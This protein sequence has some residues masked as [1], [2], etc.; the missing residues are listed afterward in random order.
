MKPTLVVLA[1]GMG[2]RY[3]GL[4]QIDEFGPSGEAIIEYSIFDAIRAGF[5]K[6]V[7]IIRKTIEKDF[8]AFIGNKFEGKIDI[9][10]AYQELDHL[11]EGFTAPEGREKPWG[12]AHAM[13]V[14]KDVVNEPFAIINADDFYGADAY[15][16]MGNFL[17]QLSNDSNSYALLGYYVKNTL[18]ENGSVSRGVCQ[19]NENNFLESITERTKIYPQDNNIVF[20]E[21][22]K[23]TTLSPETPVSMNFMG[24]TPAVFPL[25]EE[26]F[27]AFLEKDINTPKSEFF[28]PLALSLFVEEKLATVTVLETAAKWFGVTYKEDKQAAQDQLNQLIEAGKYP[29]NLR[30]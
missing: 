9:A 4:K 18:S 23:L 10:Y 21:D 6:V 11:P 14:A 24:F 2:S 17:S 13:M 15:K 5:G 25:L 1:A 3:G 22:G 7:F 12:T 19:L 28:I 20:E 16:V 27:I 26:K 30:K 8:K 29:T